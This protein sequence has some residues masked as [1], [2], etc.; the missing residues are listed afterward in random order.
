M[1]LIMGAII[2]FGAGIFFC[3][4]PEIV[5]KINLAWR[6]KDSAEPSEIYIKIVR[7]MGILLVIAGVL[8]LKTYFSI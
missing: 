5:A 4:R 2:L 6:L 3:V 7:I 8:T 1:E